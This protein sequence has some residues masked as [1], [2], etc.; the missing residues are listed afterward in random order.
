L[1]IHWTAKV[2]VIEK[3][4]AEEKAWQK[5]FIYQMNDKVLYKNVMDPKFSEIS[6]KEPSTINHCKVKWQ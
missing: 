1:G 3:N 4:N 6:W 2:N 5:M